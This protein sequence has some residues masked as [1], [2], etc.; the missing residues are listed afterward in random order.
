VPSGATLP[1]RSIFIERGRIDRI[2]PSGVEPP[3]AETIDAR[4]AFVIPGLIDMHVHACA[5]PLEKHAHA[6]GIDS[7]T[8]MGIQAAENL[9]V[10]LAAGVTTVRDLGGGPVV[11]Y[12]LKQA[13]AMRLFIGARP[14]VAGP[15]VTAVGGHGT[16]SGW[17][18]AVEVCGAE[19]M[20]RAVRTAVSRGSDVIKVATGGVATRTELTLAELVAAVDEAHWCGLKVASHAN[21]SLRGINNSIEAGCD[22]IEHGCAADRRALEEMRSRNIALCPTITVLA[23]IKE[24]SD[25]YGQKTPALTDAVQRAWRQHEEVVHQAIALGVTIVAGTDA[26]M[27]AVGFDSLHEELR[28]LVRWG[29]SPIEALRSATCAAGELLGRTEL[30]AIAP[31]SSAD[32]VLLGEDPRAD[33]SA[34]SDVRAVMLEG[35][36]VRRSPT[37]ESAA[38]GAH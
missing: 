2:T 28:W 8:R 35:R 7:P 30:G 1:K 25:V 12:D 9:R 38:P 24:R 21:F 29:M 37:L 19:E 26:G 11:P 4:G 33:L 6:T 27:P 18:L 36:L 34:L 10:A 20:R 5:S 16:E 15:M 31:G 14:L 13:W 23:R 22:S 3:L 32:L 17:R